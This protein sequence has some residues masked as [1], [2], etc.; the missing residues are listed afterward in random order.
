MP[1]GT[2]N[3]SRSCLF[4]S[5][6]NIILLSCLVLAACCHMFPF[7]QVAE[8]RLVGLT[9]SI[10]GIIYI[11]IYLYVYV[12]VYVYVYILYICICCRPHSFTSFSYC[13]TRFC[14]LGR[15]FSH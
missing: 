5:T 9:L 1:S 13:V 10:I 7:E 4:K 8:T 3:R 6:F 14:R 2:S 11:Y 15:Q 12:H